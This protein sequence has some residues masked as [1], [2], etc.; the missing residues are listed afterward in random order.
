M[1][2]YVPDWAHIH[3]MIN[4]F[5]VILAVMGAAVAL[6]GVV[7]SRRGVWV[8]ACASLTLAAITVVPTY[9]TGE[10]AEHF[11]NRPWYVARGSIHQH[12]D[13]A[14]IATILVGIAGLVALV[15]WRR[16]VRYPR[17]LS[18]PGGLRAAVVIT[19]VVAAVAIGYASLL[20]GYIVH[21]APALKGPRPAGAPAPANV[22]TGLDIVGL[23]DSTA[24]RAGGLL[25]NSTHAEVYRA[26]YATLAGLNRAATRPTT[27]A[28]YLTSRS[29]AQFVGVN[30]SSHLAVTSA[31]EAAYGIDASTRPE[32]AALG[33]TLIVTAKAFQMGLTS[34]V[35]LPGLR[36]DPHGAFA[37]LTTTTS[38]LADFKKVFDGFMA[39]LVARQLDNDVVITVEGDTP[40]TPVDFRSW[41]DATPGNHNLAYIWSGGALKSGWF[42][43]VDKTGAVT[44]FDPASG[45]ARAYDG[46]AQA[47]A[48]VAAVA[49]ALTG[50]LRRVQD[51][52]RTDITGLLR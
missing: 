12:E 43:S 26:H 45:M 21:D 32:I 31:D 42:G 36:D 13:A 6:L 41:A 19:S 27:R 5:P 22:P 35:V 7:R 48:A 47:R 3:I 50:D 17:E 28:A 15:A 49:Y 25:A 18:L 16:L 29:A 23:F 4:H 33:R 38:T 11:L 9:F 46:D 1:T 10:P 14:L 2:S 37:D 52:T 8:Y 20:G 44:G 51:F 39:D 30:L 40:K 24:S 34:S